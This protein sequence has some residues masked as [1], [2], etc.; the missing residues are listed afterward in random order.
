MSWLLHGTGMS[1]Q[2]TVRSLYTSFG[3]AIWALE[4]RCRPCAGSAAQS[5]RDHGRATA[6]S[7]LLCV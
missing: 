1:R 6:A 7:A 3:L 4:S 5:P 2:R